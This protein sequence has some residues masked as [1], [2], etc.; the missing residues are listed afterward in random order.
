MYCLEK[1]IL[2]FNYSKMTFFKYIKYT[3]EFTQNKHIFKCVYCNKRILCYFNAICIGIL[4]V[5]KVS[6]LLKRL[7]VDSFIMV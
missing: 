3:I 7:N 4:C 1:T 5:R 6:T 2:F